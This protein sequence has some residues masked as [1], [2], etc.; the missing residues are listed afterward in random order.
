MC[1]LGKR[2][3]R[4]RHYFVSSLL[5]HCNTKLKTNNNAHKRSREI[6]WNCLLRVVTKVLKFK[7]EKHRIFGSRTLFGPE[8][9]SVRVVYELCVVN[10]WR[11][12]ALYMCGIFS[13]QFNSQY[14]T[15]KMN[16]TYKRE[17]V[18]LPIYKCVLTVSMRV[19]CPNT[20]N[21]DSE[22]CRPFCRQI[23]YFICSPRLT[24]EFNQ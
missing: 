24:I 5:I 20:I 16:S 6:Q 23:L 19:C 11:R 2:L 22:H 10:V 15:N 8:E 14:P 9:T 1:F 3:L 21:I 12:C 17:R 13:I 18:N 4:L 7:H